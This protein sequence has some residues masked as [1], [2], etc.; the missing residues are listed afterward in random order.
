[1]TKLSNNERTFLTAYCMISLSFLLLVGLI[2]I[3]G[4]IQSNSPIMTYFGI[5]LLF[6]I[7]FFAMA[8]PANEPEDE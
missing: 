3:S 7:L 2:L 5:A 4:M 8:L 1:M 6:I